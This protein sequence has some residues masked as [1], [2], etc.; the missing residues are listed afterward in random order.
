MD[1]TGRLTANAAIRQAGEKQVVGFSVAVNESYRRKDGEKVTLTDYFDCS[2]WLGTGIAPYLTKGTVVE[3]SGR[4]SARAWL[5]NGEP[6]AG[7][8]FN[9][10]KIK[11]HGGGA[12]AQPEK[13]IEVYE[14]Q[15]INGGAD[16]EEHDDLPF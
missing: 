7:L 1:I 3:L 6:K 2:F 16:K 11:L 15:V 12:A 9:V 14:A 13:E 4:V 8:N 10:A 5:Y